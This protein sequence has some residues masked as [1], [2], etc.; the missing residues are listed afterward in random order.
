M[1]ILYQE[2]EFRNSSNNYMQGRFFVSPA[3]IIKIF[4][5]NISNFI[6]SKVDIFLMGTYGSICQCFYI[7]S[8]FTTGKCLEMSD[9]ALFECINNNLKSLNNEKVKGES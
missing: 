7:W 9:G 2:E 1:V 8:N 4:F 6:F 3:S 5:I